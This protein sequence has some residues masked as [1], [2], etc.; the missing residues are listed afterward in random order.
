M[1]AA[2]AGP[3]RLRRVGRLRPRLRA[4]PPGRI[5]ARER[6]FVKK[7]FKQPSFAAGVHRDEI[8]AAAELLGLELDEHIRNVIAA[9]RS[10]AGELD[11][12]S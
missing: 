5:E 11:L 7:T 2:Q 1:H 9:M 6:K 3:I 8:Y 12:R 4:R 10:I